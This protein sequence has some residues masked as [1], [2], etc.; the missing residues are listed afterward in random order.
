MATGMLFIT[1]RLLETYC[2]IVSLNWQ[3]TVQVILQVTLLIKFWFMTAVLV[4]IINWSDTLMLFVKVVYVRDKVSH[5]VGNPSWKGPPIYFLAWH[6]W[7]KAFD[8]KGTHAHWRNDA[9]EFSGILVESVICLVCIPSFTK[10]F[11]VTTFRLRALCRR[12][13]QLS[14]CYVLAQ[15]AMKF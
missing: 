14:L 7:N 2:L 13:I 4:K 5:M 3:R 11:G 6:G 12:L 1:F 8:I 15:T 9:L 10:T